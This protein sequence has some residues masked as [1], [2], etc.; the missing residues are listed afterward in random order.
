MLRRAQRA[1][2]TT[3]CVV[4]A[5]VAGI[6]CGGDSSTGPKGP[7]PAAK[8]AFTVHPSGVA[9]G[10]NVSPAVQVTVQDAQGATVPTATHTISIAI[11]SGTGT[12]GA[13]LGGTVTT[14]AV[15]GV[16]AFGNLTVDKVGTGYTLTATASGLTAAT[17]S[18]FAAKTLFSEAV[19]LALMVRRSAS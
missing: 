6:S 12:S 5:V 14:A 17:S 2:M 18:A 8:L 11:S 13:T 4:A 1:A 7:G 19:R 9:A 3:G 16:A 10:S 15:N